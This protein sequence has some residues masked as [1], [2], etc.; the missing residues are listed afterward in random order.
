MKEFTGWADWFMNDFKDFSFFDVKQ[1]HTWDDRSI[2]FTRHQ[3]RSKT[4]GEGKKGCCS[5]DNIYTERRVGEC[6]DPLLQILEQSN[7]SNDENCPVT[8][9]GSQIK[10]G[11][12]SNRTFFSSTKTK[13]T[14]MVK[15]LTPS[16]KSRQMHFASEVE[17]LPQ[18]HESET[19]TAPTCDD[20]QTNSCSASNGLPRFGSSKK[21]EQKKTMKGM[22]SFKNS[23][24]GYLVDVGG[25][26][27]LTSESNSNKNDPNHQCVLLKQVRSKKVV[28]KIFQSNHMSRRLQ[29]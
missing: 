13:P 25:N 23:D 20:E 22:V 10:S 24:R 9:N 7:L 14:K 15:G 5:N 17:C 11:S 19:V 18:I 16:R 6:D 8:N 29:K 2:H 21:T 27:N 12:V 4:D 28:K 1:H 26:S 3:S